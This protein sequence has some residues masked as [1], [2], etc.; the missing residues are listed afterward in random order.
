MIVNNDRGIH[1]SIS[2]IEVK[3]CLISIAHY[4]QCIVDPFRLLL[5]RFQCAVDII[6]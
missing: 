6:G 3:I 2:S 4:E 5:F 1:I